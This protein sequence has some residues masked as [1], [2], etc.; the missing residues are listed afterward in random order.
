MLNKW[1]QTTGEL[2]TNALRL[3]GMREPSSGERIASALIGGSNDG[4]RWSE[5]LG[6]LLSV[7]YSSARH[8][9]GYTWTHFF[10]VLL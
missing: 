6:A 10:V 1:R 4:Q 8:A 2:G 9:S 3:D 5:G 7:S